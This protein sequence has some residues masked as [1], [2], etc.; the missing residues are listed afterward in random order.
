MKRP[1]RNF[2]SRLF[3]VLAL[4]ALALLFTACAPPALVMLNPQTWWGALDMGHIYLTND[5]GTSWIPQE[6]GQGGSFLVGFD[7]W[8]SQLAL[9]VGSLAGWPPHGP[10]LKTLNGGATWEVKQ[11]YHANLNKVTFIKQ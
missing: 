5:G 2:F 3:P 6:T 11:S 1:P 9:A 7:A 8:S 4:P 10:I